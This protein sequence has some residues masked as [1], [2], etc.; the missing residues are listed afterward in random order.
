[1]LLLGVD[2][3]RA[4]ERFMIDAGFQLAEQADHVLFDHVEGDALGFGHLLQLDHGKVVQPSR[5]LDFLEL[6]G[7]LLRLLEGSLFLRQ[8]LD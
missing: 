6:L 1:M 5:R 3:G 4:L 2:H 8:E 7:P